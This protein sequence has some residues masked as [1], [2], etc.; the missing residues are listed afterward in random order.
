MRR[1]GHKKTD[2]IE[3]SP[4]LP[5]LPAINWPEEAY[6]SLVMRLDLYQDYIVAQKFEKGQG[7]ALFT[8]DPLDLA[9]ALGDLTVS[10]GL[11]PEN[12][13]FWSR[14]GGQERLGVYVAPKVWPVSVQGERLTWL[15]PLPGFVF[16]G[17]GKKY[18]LWAVKER[19]VGTTSL[20]LPPTPNTSGTVCTGNAPFPQASAKTIWQA[21]DVFFSSGFNNHLANGKSQDKKHK[22]NI[23]TRWRELHEAGAESYPLEDLVSAGRTLSRLMED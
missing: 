19:P 12:C 9:T 7:G 8:V 17:Q 16:V 1:N 18:S 23:L 22:E 6:T 21:V 2:Q 15:V 10:S 4:Y 13:L 3:I 20:F 14:A 11:L 5:I